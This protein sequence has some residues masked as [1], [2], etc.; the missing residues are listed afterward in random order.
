MVIAVLDIEP[1]TKCGCVLLNVSCGA[2]H[3]RLAS[4]SSP[5]TGPCS[6]RRLLRYLESIL[7]PWRLIVVVRHHLRDERRECLL[8]LL[9]LG[10]GAEEVGLALAAGG[11]EH[12]F[13]QPWRGVR[14]VPRLGGQLDADAVRFGLLLPAVGQLR[15]YSG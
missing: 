9:A 12:F 14:I 7:R 8:P 4:A 6:K 5:I 2:K 11:L 13:P 1:P 15:A 3:A 10:V